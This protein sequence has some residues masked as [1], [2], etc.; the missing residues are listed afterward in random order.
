MNHE[1]KRRKPWGTLLLWG[2]LSLG[3]YALV[4]I[5]GDALQQFVAVGG[6]GKAAI[7]V[8][9]AIVFSLVHGNF[10]GTFFEALGIRARGR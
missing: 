8:A 4:F 5:K 9:V 1:S 10:A 3:L 7:V 6:I 2:A